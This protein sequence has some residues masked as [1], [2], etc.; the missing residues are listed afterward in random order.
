MNISDMKIR[1][2]V[3]SALNTNLGV[4]SIGE[5]EL[6]TQQTFDSI[7][8]LFPDSNITLLET[9]RQP[10]SANQKEFVRDNGV[11]LFDLTEDP[12]VVDV[13]DRHLLPDYAAT[14]KNLLVTY[15]TSK[16]L[17]TAS[18]DEEFIAMMSGRYKLSRDFMPDMLPGRI[19]LPHPVIETNR[20]ASWTSGMEHQ[21]LCYFYAWDV[22]LTRS[23]KELHDRMHAEMVEERKIDNN[24]DIEHL[25]YKFR[26]TELIHH[27]DKFKIE[28][29]VASSGSR[30]R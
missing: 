8:H 28:G 24:P 4:F 14:I 6:Q 29:A 19:S 15:A 1:F 16:C 5:R 3:T 30:I 20:G 11:E 18:F 23:V 26:S 9:S 17:S 25:M 12:Y 27:T 22:S 21:Y 13:Y 7:R 10:L 2:I